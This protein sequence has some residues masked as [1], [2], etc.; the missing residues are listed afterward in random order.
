M[1]VSRYGSEVAWPVLDYAGIGKDG[2]Y[3]HPLRYDLEKMSLGSIGTEWDR[4]VWTKYV[5]I[6][7][8]NR[9]RAFWGLKPLIITLEPKDIPSLLKAHR[10]RFFWKRE[11][12]I[13]DR[14]A[15]A[16]LV[17]IYHSIYGE[18][19]R[20]GLFHW[21]KRRGNHFVLAEVSSL[22]DHEFENFKAVRKELRHV[23]ARQ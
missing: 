10:T 14:A 1:V 17:G 8:K 5:P 19:S 22:Y 2:N 13:G 20:T 12:E 15:G 3:S 21:F 6:N 4:L 16:D 11:Y 7:H 23:P 18:K 9:H